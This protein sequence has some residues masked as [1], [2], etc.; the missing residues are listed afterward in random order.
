MKLRKL[1]EK[2]LQET[3]GGDFCVGSGSSYVL[4]YDVGCGGTGGGYGYRST[5]TSFGGGANNEDLRQMAER[6]LLSGE[7]NLSASP[8][9]DS[10][11]LSGIASLYGNGREMF[12]TRTDS[13]PGRAGIW[14]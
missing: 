1:S 6:W 13:S 9:N 4:V 10:E 8:V 5:P 2:E 3:V 11:R 12:T 14:D 7:S